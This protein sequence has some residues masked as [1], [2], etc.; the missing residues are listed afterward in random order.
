MNNKKLIGIAMA[1]AAALA[2]SAIPVTTAFAA[3]APGVKCFGANACKGK[4]ACKTA[5]NACKGQNSCKGKGIAMMN[6]DAAC[7]AAGGKTTES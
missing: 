4:S 1:T 3:D 2:F 6:D 7:T 5:K